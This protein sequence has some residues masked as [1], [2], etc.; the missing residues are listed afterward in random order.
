MTSAELIQAFL[1]GLGV[2]SQQWEQWL[3][4]W[5]RL[6]PLVVLVPA[7]GLRAAPAP[8]RAALA[9]SLAVAVA[10]VV[11]PTAPEAPFPVALAAEFVRG[12]PLAVVAATTLWIATMAGGLI[13]NLR[14]SQEGTGLP[15]VETGSTP[16]GALLSMLVAVAF[17]QGGG[18]AQAALAIAR[19]EPVTRQAFASLANTLAGGVALAAAIAAPVLAVSLVVEVASALLARAATPAFIQPTLAPLRTLAILGVSALLLDRMA[20]FLV[21]TLPWR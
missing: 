8:M 6:T 4:A 2:S 14:S 20:E 12:I 3:R 9:L 13:D 1:D 18:A 19:S 16:L 7:F 5:A 17:L 10:P 15:N 11:Q 21:L